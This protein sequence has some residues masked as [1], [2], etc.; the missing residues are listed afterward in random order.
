MSQVNVARV[1]GGDVAEV[2]E[3]L[4]RFFSEE[5]FELPDEGLEARLARYVS[6]THHAVFAARDGDRAVAAATVMATFGLE[7]G[8][9]AELEDLYV[10]PD[11]RGTGV[12]RALVEA[13]ARWAGDQGCAALLVT[14]TPQGQEAHDLMG[15]YRHLGFSDE[16]RR[17]LE[18]SLRR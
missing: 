17:I 9:V 15:F 11:H 3:L 13:S 14:V 1:A 4:A 5:G 18:L 10:V 12:A 8:W 16:G 2:G 7:Y 6:L